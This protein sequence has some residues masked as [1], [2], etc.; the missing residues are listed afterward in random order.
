MGPTTAV[1][2]PQELI[3]EVISHLRD[4]KTM[5][6]TCSLVNHA[7]SP[8]ARKLLFRS[9]HVSPAK[10]P[11]TPHEDYSSVDV[12]DWSAF[13]RLF[14]SMPRLASW[15][16]ELHI[17][18][19]STS[20]QRPISNFGGGLGDGSDD[21]GY[22]QSP[23]DKW[24]YIFPGIDTLYAVSQVLPKLRHMYLRDLVIKPGTQLPYHP[25]PL[26]TL[27]LKNVGVMLQGNVLWE[28]FRLFSPREH[29]LLDVFWRPSME[30][31][32][33]EPPSAPPSSSF[34][35]RAWHLRGNPS[36]EYVLC[37]L[38]STS[39]I[40]H[41][42]SLDVALSDDIELLALV[43]LMKKSGSTLK[44]LKLDV[45]EAF[46]TFDQDVLMMCK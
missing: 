6:S 8:F 12:P 1:R 33:Q 28:L 14:G 42:H 13:P 27:S 44:E 25:T 22:W 41:A 18:G 32:I 11:T 34:V 26:D 17:K 45:R 10:M 38:A 5:L 39:F 36:V 43:A 3:D 23:D 29:V 4:D 21:E 46:F 37:H 19:T 16:T 30:W 24:H 40:N 2:L 15:V 7:W 9:V 35:A 20:A 31:T